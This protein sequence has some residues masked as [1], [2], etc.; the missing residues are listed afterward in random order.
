M[1]TQR[2]LDRGVPIEDACNW[3]ASAAASAITWSA[4]EHMAGAFNLVQTKVME[5]TLH[6][7][8]DPRTG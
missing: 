7:G 4:A 1:G 6:D 8:L 2:Y 5:V 3:N